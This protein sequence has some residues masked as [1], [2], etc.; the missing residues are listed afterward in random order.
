MSTE[1]Q[2]FV[3]KPHARTFFRERTPAKHARAV[4]LFEG[5]ARAAERLFELPALAGARTIRVGHERV[6]APV[7]R[8]AIER[9]LEVFVPTPRLA[10]GFRRFS[11]DRRDGFTAIEALPAIDVMI[12]AALAV[13]RDGYF[14]GA[15]GG[16][17][18][19]EYVILRALGRPAIPVATIAHPTQLVRWFPAYEHDVPVS[20]VATPDAL[21]VVDN[22]PPPPRT[23][24]WAR[25]PKDRL[26]SVPIL[27]RLPRDDA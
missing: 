13:A 14:V 4:P 5:A 3:G 8:L 18:D 25:L 21:V 12:V 20:A 7:R 6:L 22:P 24:E 27:G 1:G 16:W 26:R 23:V 19:L 17:S 9:G 11:R 10:R 15:G 2:Y